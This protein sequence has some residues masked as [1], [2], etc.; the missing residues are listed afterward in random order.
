MP[1][2]RSRPRITRFTIEKEKRMLKMIKIL[3]LRKCI[4]KHE[5]ANLLGI[6]PETLQTYIHEA[7]R[8]YG[9]EIYKHHN[10]I[11]IE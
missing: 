6:G 10:M 3:Q 8:N 5:L 2:R 11:C 7:Y 4:N 1:R 9:I